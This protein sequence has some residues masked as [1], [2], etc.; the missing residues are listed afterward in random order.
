MAARLA[1]RRPA[2][3]LTSHSLNHPVSRAV[4]P[5]CLFG[6]LGTDATTAD[7]L[8]FAST[9]AA[10][11]PVRTAQ[12]RN[13]PFP[14]SPIPRTERPE[15]A[16]PPT[17]PDASCSAFALPFARAATVSR[18]CRRDTA[19]DRPLR[20]YPRAARR[21]SDR[22]FIG[23]PPPPA[24]CRLL[25]RN[26]T[27][28]RPRTARPSTSRAASCA[29]AEWRPLKSGA[30]RVFSGQGSDGRTRCVTP[31]STTARAGGF[32]PT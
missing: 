15:G 10:G 16:L 6:P 29:R 20:L 27:R 17:S 11:I 30:S 4:S 26:V 5:G 19:S 1:P 31:T 18:L 8:W 12:A 14:S 32:T 22:L 3:A 23:A 24:A 13:A 9:A 21:R 7:T 28:A 2:A 25:Q